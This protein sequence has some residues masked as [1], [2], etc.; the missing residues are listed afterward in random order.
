MLGIIY[1]GNND[2]WL[3]NE[4]IENKGILFGDKNIVKNE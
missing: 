2:Y 4:M 3:L 1:L